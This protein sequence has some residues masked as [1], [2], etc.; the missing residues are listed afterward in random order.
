MRNVI[1]WLVLSF[2]AVLRAEAVP[3]KPP[4]C[5]PGYYSAVF[6]TLDRPW[7][8]VEQDATNGQFRFTYECPARHGTL[9]FEH[10]PCD[11]TTAPAYFNEAANRINHGSSRQRGKFE[12]ISEFELRA[13]KD[14]R[15]LTQSIWLFVLP[16][17]IQIWTWTFPRQGPE[18]GPGTL[19]ALRQCVNRQRYEDA[20]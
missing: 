7:R 19:Q 12:D 1:C 13:R 3:V 16:R 4:P 18:A 11:R 10:L 5:L 8:L 15:N 6:A 9:V 14:S 17:S 2:A 20:H